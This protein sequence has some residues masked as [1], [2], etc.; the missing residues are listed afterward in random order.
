MKSFQIHVFTN[1]ERVVM[2]Y[3]V[4]PDHK[5]SQAIPVADHVDLESLVLVL[6]GESA[7]EAIFS[8]LEP[9]E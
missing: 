6:G 4:D 1:R 2:M 3:L 5:R 9:E 8:G 7:L